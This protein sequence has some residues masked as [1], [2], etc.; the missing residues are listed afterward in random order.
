M[1]KFVPFDEIDSTHIR[2]IAESMTVCPEFHRPLADDVMA[3]L[4]AGRAKLFAF[5]DGLMILSVEQHNVSGERR[6][7]IDAWSGDGSIFRRAE[8]ASDLRRIAADWQCDVIETL[9][10]DL[11]LASAI[12]SIGGHVESICVTLPVSL[13]ERVN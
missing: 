10:F 4:K 8:A 3:D 13:A 1:L 7:L 11:R 6:L 9:V 5:E 12:C 2:A